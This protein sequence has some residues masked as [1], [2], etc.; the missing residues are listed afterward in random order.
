MERFTWTELADM[1]QVYGAACGN[2]RAARHIYQEWHP[3]RRVPHYTMFASVGRRLRERVSFTRAD[4]QGR[5]RT[6]TTPAFEEDV[7]QRVE[8]NPATSTRAIAHI[9][10]SSPATVWRVLRD[11][12]LFPYHWQHVQV[13]GPRDN[14]QRLQ[15]V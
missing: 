11:Q 14:P 5:R 6:V 2:S 9:I 8:R 12:P 3:N 7:L 15:F 10:R 4:G 13:M 1:V